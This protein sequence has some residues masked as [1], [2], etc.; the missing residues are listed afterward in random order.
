MS[1]VYF[2]LTE[3]FNAR[4]DIAVLTSGQAVVHYR[5]AIMSKD[6][7][8]IL[9]ETPEAC[10]RVIEELAGRGATY[11]P[12]APLD[13]RWLSGGWSSH[14]QFLDDRGRRVRC[15]FFSRPPRVE[16]DTVE[17]LFSGRDDS[18]LCVL[19]VD[20]LIRMKRTQRAKDYAVI[21]ELARL[22][23]PQR[24]IEVTT[25]PDR[26]IELA[27]ACG[28]AS[29]R[30]AV[31]RARAGGTREEVSVALAR[32]ANAFQQA[33][34]TRLEVYQKAADAYFREFRTAGIDGMPLRDAHRACLEL[35]GQL[36][37][38]DPLGEGGGGT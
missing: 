28:E 34:R 8:W 32:E 37:P 23:S 21:G 9:R 6:G 24:E 17:G 2:E 16:R 30:E 19:D 26:I 25:D 22:L 10:E 38:R 1:N 35:A 4:G 11:R 27:L 14:F 33:D 29:Q 31:V 13:V 12:G 5:I 36:L 7:D 20:S 18:P 15:D 3:R